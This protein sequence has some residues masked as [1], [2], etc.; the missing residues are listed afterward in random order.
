M[1]DQ[2]LLQA[3]V[4]N[5][6]TD[7]RRWPQPEGH[8]VHNKDRGETNFVP[9]PLDSSP[10]MAEIDPLGMS[11]KQPGAKL[12]AGKV[13]VMRGAWF[14]FPR[15]LKQVARV[16]EA[17]ARKY[18]W[19]GWEKVP[20]GITRYT[21]ALGRHIYEDPFATD[22]GEGGLG[23]DYLHAA[24][25]AWNALARLELIMREQEENNDG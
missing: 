16:S 11:P 22:S 2:F 6:S 14:Y 9:T 17:G 25:V 15:A 23:D 5:P 13:D 7:G 24:Q 3:S 4:L 8:F 19:K 21:A 1:P 12:D 18:S 10:K 20:D